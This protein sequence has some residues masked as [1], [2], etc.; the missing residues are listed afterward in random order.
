MDAKHFKI[1]DHAVWNSEVGYVSGVITKTNWVPMLMILLSWLM[2][3]RS[4]VSSTRVTPVT[5]QILRAV[6]KTE[7]PKW[8]SRRNKSGKSGVILELES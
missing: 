2:A 8:D 6:F 4:L 5:L 7:C 1:G 3:M